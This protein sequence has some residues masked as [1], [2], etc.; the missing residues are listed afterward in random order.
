MSID[1]E[2]IIRQIDKKFRPD[3]QVYLGEA[4]DLMETHSINRDQ[5]NWSQLRESVLAELDSS[6][7]ADVHR[8][9]R[10]ALEQ[11]GDSHS[12]LLEPERRSLRAAGAF[13]KYYPAPK[14]NWMD[15]EVGCLTVPAFSGSEDAAR[16][17]ASTLHGIIEEFDSQGPCGWIV[18]LRD[19]TGGNMW[20]MLAG[21]GPLLQGEIA[22]AFVDSQG[23]RQS[24]VYR[25]GKAGIDASLQSY[26][27]DDLYRVR[28]DL[29]I[30]VLQNGQTSSSGEAVVIAFRGR[31]HTRT[32]GLPTAGLTTSNQTFELSDGAALLLTTK[33]FA[34][35]AGKRHDGPLIPDEHVK[36]DDNVS[37]QA[38]QWLLKRR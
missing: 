34:D 26:V 32:F 18:D 31:P 23:A 4:I 13:D 11:L 17:Y 12:F 38:I 29:P 6:S 28:R 22:G 9:I 25:D 27:E 3:R 36:D 24:W 8:A 35:R 15:E 16:V 37:D 2:E 30:A 7:P 14:G 1:V 33:F 21:I 20:P 10:F 19:N 5:V